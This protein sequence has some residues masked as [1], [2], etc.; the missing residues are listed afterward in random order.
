MR[1]VDLVVE[2][3]ELDLALGLDG[4]GRVMDDL[5]LSHS[6]LSNKF[7]ELKRYRACEPI[8]LPVTL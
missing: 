6:S 7:S 1:A 3:V 8:L 5:T 2:V 4:L